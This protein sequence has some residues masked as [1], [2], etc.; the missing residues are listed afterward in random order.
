MRSAARCARP[1]AAAIR[2]R[3]RAGRTLTGEAGAARRRRVARLVSRRHGR[4]DR[5]AATSPAT[6]DEPAAAARG[7]VA[8]LCATNAQ[9]AAMQAAL[10]ALG[11]PS[12]LSRR[13][14][15]VR[16]RRGGGARPRRA[17]AGGAGRHVARCRRVADAAHRLR[18]SDELVRRPARRGGLGSVGRDAS[19][20]GTRPGVES[21]FTVAFRRLLDDRGVLRTHPLP[22]PR[23]RAPSDQH[24]APGRAAAA[25]PRREERRGPLAL[26]E[27]LQ[28]MRN[29]PCARVPSAVGEAAQIRLES[30]EQALKLTTVHK[31]KGLEYPVVV[32]PVSLG[33]QL[34]C[35]DNDKH[36][37]LPR[38]HAT[39]QR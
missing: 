12:V 2:G 8:V 31:S 16:D 35:T 19:G 27:W 30:D 28:R 13:A 15:R 23:R 32:L 24:A 38:C 5:A 1:R 22:A 26:V 17:R 20:A 37:A 36:R 6:L 29:D 34:W 7:D 14:Q 25:R 39:A 21:G 10:R 18:R 33:R 3:R 11:V 9:S 4:R